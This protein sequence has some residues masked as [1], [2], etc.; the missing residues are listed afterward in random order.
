M[1]CEY[2]R[3]GFHEW[4]EEYGKAAKFHISRSIILAK[5]IMLN[6]FTPQEHMK[7][8]NDLL[9]VLCARHINKKDH[10]RPANDIKKA[11]NSDKALERQILLIKNLA[12][13]YSVV[14]ILKELKDKVMYSQN[15]T[16]LFDKDIIYKLYR[17]ELDEKTVGSSAGTKDDQKNKFLE[18]LRLE[19][20]NGI[21]FPL[22]NFFA[23]YWPSAGELFELLS[24]LLKEVERSLHTYNPQ[25]AALS[26]WIQAI[27]K[28]LLSTRNERSYEILKQSHGIFD[29]SLEC[30]R[31]KS[32]K[33]REIR[34]ICDFLNSSH[35]TAGINI[36]DF[37][38]SWL[39]LLFVPMI[40]SISG[41]FEEL[42]TFLM[43]MLNDFEQ[44]RKRIDEIWPSSYSQ[45][46]LVLSLDSSISS[47]KENE[48]TFIE[49][50]KNPDAVDPKE[51]MLARIV[52]LQ[53]FN[54]FLYRL[55]KFDE[56]PPWQKIAYFFIKV[57]Q[58][59]ESTFINE[60]SKMKIEELT[61]LAEK[62]Y[63]SV[64]SQ[65]DITEQVTLNESLFA[66]FKRIAQKDNF[67]FVGRDRFYKK[68]LKERGCLRIPCLQTPLQE[69]FKDG[70]DSIEI[71]RKWVKFL[72]IHMLK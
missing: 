61:N 58:I 63:L 25:K 3:I 14:L 11:T 12:A 27:M 67:F 21:K 64:I 50:T 53:D 44:G 62:E 38:D 45:D 35:G 31:Y 65:F 7:L 30:Q 10:C 28:R 40:S 60:Y 32:L 37:V 24:L 19:V 72:S 42:K 8:E 47:D 6:S 29:C 26:T 41:T 68:H 71:V 43:R 69:Y 23:P 66:E 33:R 55:I 16:E 46:N 9:I 13:I 48:T 70:Q 2:E 56:C 36:E 57:L 18:P 4:F 39:S 52:A 5:K 17:K 15:F 34:K 51:E 20:V 59:E 49:I 54:T 1:K 22:K